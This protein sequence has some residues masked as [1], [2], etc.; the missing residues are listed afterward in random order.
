M[1]EKHDWTSADG[2]VVLLH[3]DMVKCLKE[4]E[5]NAFD[6]IVTDPPYGLGMDKWDTFAAAGKRVKEGYLENKERDA[7]LMAVNTWAR[8]WAMA[9]M[10]VLKPG[11]YFVTFSASRTFHQVWCGLEDAGL[12]VQDTLLWLYGS[13]MPKSPSVLKPAF[14]PIALARKPREGTIEANMK[15]H[16]TGS[17]NIDACRGQGGQGLNK[18]AS[19]TLARRWVTTGK[20]EQGRW[21]ANVMLDEIA[22]S[23]I[24]TQW[25]GASRFFYCPKVSSKE[26]GD[27]DHPTVKPVELMRWL[28]RLATPRGG[29][30]L[31]CFVGSGTT[32]VA[33]VLEGY[34]CTAIERDADFLKIARKRIEAAILERDAVA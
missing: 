25:N 15:K 13:S 8:E 22:A 7:A 9:A 2:S 24:E 17:L 1:C 10:H 29:A 27:N 21:P 19:A 16:G 33:A 4:M 28:V 34:R 3:D 5:A 11:G 30:V 14:E 31:D 26:R 12:E 6:A 18:D 23:M 32:A 20:S